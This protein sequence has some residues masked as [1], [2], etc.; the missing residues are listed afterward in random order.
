ML[1]NQCIACFQ[2]NGETLEVMMKGMQ[3]GLLIGH[4][5]SLHDAFPLEIFNVAVVE[6]K[7]IIL[8][9]VRD[10]STGFAMLMGTIYCLNLE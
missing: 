4:K 2:A 6:K 5:G 1:V 7:K 10:V 8:H 3:V 9:D